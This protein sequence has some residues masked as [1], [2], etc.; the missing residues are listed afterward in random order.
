[1]T[2]TAQKLMQTF[3]QKKKSLAVVIDEFGGTSGIV[4][5]YDGIFHQGIMHLLGKR[6]TLHSQVL[7]MIDLL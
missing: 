5:L 3:L 7:L 6:L 1:E 4:S 2:M